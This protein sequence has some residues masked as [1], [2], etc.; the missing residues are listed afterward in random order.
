M[1]QELSTLFSDLDTLSEEGGNAS[2]AV[3]R[4][5]QAGYNP[6]D[7]FPVFAAYKKTGVIPE[8]GAGTALLQG[9]TFGFSEEIGGAVSGNYDEYVA[10]ERAK[11]KLY[12][13][14]H[15]V[16]SAGMEILGSIPSMFIPG[17]VILK[18]TQA[19]SKAAKMAQTSQAARAAVQAGAAPSVTSTVVRGA[20]AGAAEGALY[21]LGTGVGG[22]EGKVENALQEGAIGGLFG[23]LASPLT[24][25]FSSGG[26]PTNLTDTEQATRSLAGGST[27]P[28][29]QSFVGSITPQTQDKIIGDL[30]DSDKAGLTIADVGGVETQRILRTIRTIDPEAQGYIDRVLGERFT[31]QYDRVT[32]MIDEAFENSED[33]ISVTKKSLEE[34]QKAASLAYTEAFVRHTDIQDAGLNALIRNDEEFVKAYDNTRNAILRSLKNKTDDVSVAKRKALEATPLGKNLDDESRL[35]L[36][37]LHNMKVDLDTQGT[38]NPL[39][40]AKGA[41]Y[42]RNKTLAAMSDDLATAVDKATGGDYGKLISNFADGKKLEEALELGKKYKGLSADDLRTKLSRMTS[43]EADL[44][45]TGVLDSLYLRI[46]GV[47]YNTDTVRALL[48]SPL[49]TEQ[50]RAVFPTEAAWKRFSAQMANEASM[51]RTNQLVKGGSNTADKLAD[52]QASQS[53]L[54]DA[55]AIMEDPTGITSGGALAR[56]ISSF[57]KGLSAKLRTTSNTRGIQAK[58]LLETDPA[59]R[60]EYAKQIRDARQR[61]LMESATAAEAGVKGGRVAGAAGARLGNDEQ[62]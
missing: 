3:N 20:G 8:A 46:K 13:D 53:L 52:V 37:I 43:S 40:P 28:L 26:R 33:L 23:G 9:A 6:N 61:L 25:M 5:A 41:E 18:G 38:Y 4:I 7:V 15:P 42:F 62:F 47:L 34:Q 54:A 50:L 27:L 39:S 36:D 31:E 1:K 60:V 24:R 35:S 48:K 59:K 21:G 49:L 11:Y 45:M 32:N 56:L 17:G 51:Q 57:A 30:A 16:L 12:Q 19:A 29:P 2:D 14:A 44:Y 10:L 58:I 22:V 55:K